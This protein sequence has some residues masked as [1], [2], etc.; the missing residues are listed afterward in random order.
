MVDQQA[1]PTESSTVALIEARAAAADAHPDDEISSE[2]FWAT[3]R[4]RYP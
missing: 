3:I 1:S 4:R 2:E